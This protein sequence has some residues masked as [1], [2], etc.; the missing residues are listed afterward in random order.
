[1]NAA[2]INPGGN[3]VPVDDDHDHKM[4]E[5]TL[6]V[7]EP[8]IH[9]PGYMMTL[10]Y[11]WD[12]SWLTINDSTEE[13]CN[14]G[15]IGGNLNVSL[16]CALLFTTFVPLYYNEPAR[17]TDPNDAAVLEIRLGFLNSI[18]PIALSL[19]MIHDIYDTTYFVACAG[20][21]FGTMLSVFYMLAANE[22]HNDTKTFVLMRCLG[23]KI[24]NLP[25]YFFSTGIMAWAFGGFVQAFL[26]PRTATGFTMTFF[27][28]FLMIVVLVFLALPKM[29]QGVFIGKHE[30][31]KNPPLFVDEAVIT[32]KLDSFL[33]DNATK[34]ADISLEEFHRHLTTMTKTGYRPPLQA[35]SKLVATKMYYEEMGKLAKLTGEQLDIF[36]ASKL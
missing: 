29:I 31:Q 14:A 33:K 24:S 28:I 22:C 6:T 20:T 21:L 27:L 19:D 7:E 10:F 3:H 4:K 26:V 12:A 34:N 13:N 32:A 30:E 23:P 1:M 11:M 8:E 25:Y 36:V 18:S 2:K 9:V 5:Q 15:F 17:L 16:V 35:I